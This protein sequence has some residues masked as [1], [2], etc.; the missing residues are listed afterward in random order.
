MTP[1]KKIIVFLFLGLLG[2]FFQV[3]AE[4]AEISTPPAPTLAASAYILQD[5]HTGKVLA[6]NNADTR[7]APVHV[8]LL[9][10]VIRFGLKIC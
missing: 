7:L 4:S 5:F 1:F 3:H 8:C 6:E 10:W 9:N 2:S